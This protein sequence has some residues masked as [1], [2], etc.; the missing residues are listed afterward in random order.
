MTKE[1]LLKP[2][3]KVIADFPDSDFKVGSIEDRNW[4][5]YVNGEDA[6]DGIAWNI[7]DFPHL[8]KELEWWEE[9]AI[10]DLPDY[11]KYQKKIYKAYWKC[12]ASVRCEKHPSDGLGLD[13]DWGSC[14]PA[15]EEEYLSALAQLEAAKGSR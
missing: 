7:S 11:V 9:R 1:Q 13:A 10:E 15:T 2:R 8:F 6:T 14:L 4:C 3:W 5:K 12:E